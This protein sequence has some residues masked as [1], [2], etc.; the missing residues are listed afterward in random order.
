MFVPMFCIDIKDLRRWSLGFG[1][2]DKNILII[3]ES[4]VFREYNNQ[5]KNIK[6]PVPL[7]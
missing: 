7:F 2:D 5:K 1:I 4:E 6:A 3:T